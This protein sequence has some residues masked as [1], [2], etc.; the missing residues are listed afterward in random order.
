MYSAAYTKKYR[1]RE[2]KKQKKGEITRVQ[3]V[4]C[5]RK[6]GIVKKVLEWKRKRILCPEY[7]IGRKREW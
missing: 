6:D 2:K 5:G 1:T 4:E 7:R 3:Y